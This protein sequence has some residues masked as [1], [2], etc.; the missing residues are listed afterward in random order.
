MPM[1]MAHKYVS[2]K[3][4]IIYGEEDMLVGLSSFLTEIGIIPVLC[5]TGGTSGNLATAI[6]QVTADTLLEQPQVFE[7]MDFFEIAELA[8]TLQP[9][10]I[11]GHSKGYQL[12]K[13]LNIPLIRVGF[14]PIH[15]RIGGQRILTSAMPEHS[16][17]LTR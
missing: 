10:L 17:S 1:W 3:R 4:A 5:A 15:D 6:S 7:G 2:G 13:K 9:D 12:T 8:E 14:F 16:N 11:V